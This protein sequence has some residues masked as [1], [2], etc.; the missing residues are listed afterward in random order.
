[1]AQT[2]KQRRRTKHRGN[3]VGMIESRGRTGRKAEAP[4]KDSSKDRSAAVRRRE[5]GTKPPTWKSAINRAGLSAVVLFAL[6]VLLFDQ[7]LASAFGLAAV[8]LAIYIPIGYFTDSFMYKRRM[9]QA[10]R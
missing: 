7:E 3:A 6:M 9:A 1:M 8:A 10:K 5:R 4:A 2:K